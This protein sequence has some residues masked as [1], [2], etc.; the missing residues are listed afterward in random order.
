VTYDELLTRLRNHITILSGRKG[1][2][3]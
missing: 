3:E 2:K 1:K